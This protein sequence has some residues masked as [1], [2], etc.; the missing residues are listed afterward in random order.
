[1][2]CADAFARRQMVSRTLGLMGA[3]V[4]LSPCAWAVPSSHDQSVEPYGQLWIDNYQHVAREFQLWIAGVS[5]VGWLTDGPWA[6]RKCIGSSLVINPKGEIAATGSYGPDADEIIHVEVSPVPRPA[7]GHGWEK[8]W[9]REVDRRSGMPPG[10]D[11][12]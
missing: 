8:Y 6:G 7:R 1:M 11:S 5:N 9:E 2:I 3:D 10:R 4:I 12:P